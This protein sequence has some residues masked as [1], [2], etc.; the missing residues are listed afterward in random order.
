MK[1]RFFKAFFRKFYISNQLKF[2]FEEKSGLKEDFYP[3]FKPLLRT[4]ILSGQ[5]AECS[6][7]M[8]LLA[9]LIASPAR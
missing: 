8:L 3:S 1:H 5:I 9:R 7:I 6:Q 4:I 2:A